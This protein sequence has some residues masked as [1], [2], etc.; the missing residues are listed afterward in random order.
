MFKPSMHLFD[1][2]IA[3]CL[4]LLFRFYP[5]PYLFIFMVPN[6]LY[7]GLISVFRWYDRKGCL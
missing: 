4:R 2:C 5:S 7:M 6:V 3:S 1:N